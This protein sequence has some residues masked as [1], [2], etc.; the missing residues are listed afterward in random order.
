M[1]YFSNGAEGMDYYDQYCARCVHESEDRACAVWGAHLSSN[2]QEC[3]KPDSILH[4]LIPRSPDGLG[5][6]QCR[7]F[8]EQTPQPL[9]RV[10]PQDRDAPVGTSR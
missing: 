3:N 6:E 10:L 7:M 9:R 1:G 2:Y 5:N 4:Q 8:H